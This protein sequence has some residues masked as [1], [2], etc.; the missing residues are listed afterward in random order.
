[1][2]RP[3][4][5]NMT[6][7]Q[8]L[9]NSFQ[10][11]INLL[12]AGS[13]DPENDAEWK[14]NIPYAKDVQPVLCRDTWLVSNIANNEGIMPINAQGQVHPA[15][16]IVVSSIGSGIR[17]W[18]PIVYPN[19]LEIV[20]FDGGLYYLDRTEVGN[21]PFVSVSFT[22]EQA[23][24]KWVHLTG[25][26]FIPFGLKG[27]TYK[28]ATD[29]SNELVA[30]DILKEG[31]YIITQEQLDDSQS[32]GGVFVSF[33]EV[34][35]NWKRFSHG[36]DPLNPQS[37]SLSNN[38]PGIP[39][40]TQSWSFNGSQVFSAFNTGSRVGFVS[41][42]RL[43]NFT[44]RAT[45]SVPTPG[46]ND[47][48]GIVIAFV[49]DQNDLVPNQAF[50]LDPQQFVGINV[51]DQFI[52]NQHT[53]SFIRGR[54]NISFDC[55]LIYNY[56]KLDQVIIYTFP[57]PWRTINNWAGASV[58]VEII[59]VVDLITL[60]TTDFSDAPEGK[61]ELRFDYTFD[62]ASLP[63]TQ[64]FRGP[65]RYGFVVHSQPNAT[66]SNIQIEGYGVNEIYDLRNGNVWRANGTNNWAVDPNR[67]VWDDLLPRT[68]VHNPRYGTLVWLREP[69]DFLVIDTGG[70][71]GGQMLA[72][73]GLSVDGDGFSVLGDDIN[74]S[75]WGNT[76]RPEYQDAEFNFKGFLN[77][78]YTN[79]FEVVQKNVSIYSGDFAKFADQTIYGFREYFLGDTYF[80]ENNNV[81][82]GAVDRIV[83][84]E[85]P[86]SDFFTDYVMMEEDSTFH[87]HELRKKSSANDGEVLIQE[88]VYNNTAYYSLEVSIRQNGG[89]RRQ[90]GFVFSAS[91]NGQTSGTFFDN[92][93]KGM[94]YAGDYEANFTARSLVTK[95]FVEGLIALNPGPEGPQGADGHPGEFREFE[96]KLQWR[97]TEEDD[98]VD[99]ITLDNPVDEDQFDIDEDGKLVL[100]TDEVPTEGSP[101]F[102]TSGDLYQYEQDNP[103]G[104]V[105]ELVF[106]PASH[107]FAG[108]GV[109]KIHFSED[110][111]VIVR[112]NDGRRIMIS[113]DGISYRLAT[114]AT[115]S[116]A[117]YGVIEIDGVWIATGRTGSQRSVD[118]GRT[119]TNITFPESRELNQVAKGHGVLVACAQNGI[120]NRGMRSLD[121]GETWSLVNTA[122]DNA[123]TGCFSAY[124]VFYMVASSGTGQLQRS[125]DLGENF[126]A[127]TVPNGSWNRGVG[128]KGLVVL[129]S[130]GGSGNKIAV[131][132]DN[133]ETF[134]TRTNGFNSDNIGGVCV[135]DGYIYTASA[136][137][138]ILRS[139]DVVD[140]EIVGEFADTAFQ[141][142]QGGI[143]NGKKIL[144]AVST[145]GTQRVL[146]TGESLL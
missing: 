89:T 104:E 121:K 101:R 75:V 88:W 125:T 62:L 5:T 74:L 115:N 86:N 117:L 33:E 82:D 19:V 20:F 45:F 119:W 46:D 108:S 67:S 63:Q 24:G 120:G 106:A 15:W 61:G 39:A 68:L 11:I 8:R 133:G 92:N 77:S 109:R 113:E 59:R 132:T 100:K 22:Q 103:R 54:N 16:R 17:I 99:L 102:L 29:N 48:I 128:F 30:E 10:A 31:N 80:K 9:L 43:L 127:V 42:I 1:M 107:P 28:I 83:E 12:N 65:A 37:P 25:G 131:S 142:I 90:I 93:N 32:E 69:E 81:Y 146:M 34:F 44:L 87:Q 91:A 137:G 140:W 118:K 96:N 79:F 112:S 144:V 135:F 64:K 58:D 26:A 111:C 71:G 136:S 7:V 21:G 85:L 98:W 78:F 51:T 35:T 6:N 123:Y 23:A 40:Q 139:R 27:Q 122:N 55:A 97:L 84:A 129:T 60:R 110:L 126:T 56:G 18:S 134:T 4:Q 72:R 49:E 70:T 116:F 141:D 47:F 2:L 114:T 36:G 105:D 41:D 138:R 130:T 50:G 52:P 13:M 14:P 95:Q 73:K 145:S 3:G 124:G 53:L 57:D 66:F 38:I 143:L 94:V 76:G